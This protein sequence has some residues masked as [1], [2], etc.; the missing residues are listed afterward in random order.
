L[1]ILKKRGPYALLVI[2]FTFILTGCM[3]GVGATNTGW[4]VLT[5]EDDVVYTVLSTGTVVALDATNLGAELWRYPIQQASG[6]GGLGGLFGGSRNTNTERPLQA[7]YGPPAVTDDLVLA[8][9]FDGM[10]YAFDRE[11]G[12]VLWTLSAGDA[13]I[14]SVTLYDDIVYYGSSDHNVYAVDAATREPVWDEP[15]ATENWVWGAPAVDET[16]VY[17]GSMDRH[18]YAIDRATGREVWRFDVGASVPGDL[19]LSNGVLFVGG[20]DSRMRALDKETGRELW[21][22]EDLGGWVWGEAL[23]HEDY[24]YFGSLNGLVH[25]RR[26]SDGDLRWMPAEVEGVLR[27]GPAMLDD[28]HIIVGTNAGSI[29][30]IQMEEGSQELIYNAGGAAVLSTPAVEG[31]AIYVGTAAGNVYALDLNRRDPI[32]W[33]YPAD[34]R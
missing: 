27:A 7:V 5:A 6:G 25:A 16:R 29:Y 2:L 18:V 19:T 1:N 15:F 21:R 26:V 32:L 17:V 10:V 24:V 34:I 13:I 11:T 28:K 12:R 20:V 4:T 14:G 8:T 3:P 33:T 30:A 23:V 22:T 9:T 31:S